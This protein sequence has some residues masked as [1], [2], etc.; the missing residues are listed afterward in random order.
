MC[1]ECFSLNLI[2]TE[3]NEVQNKTGIYLV[4]WKPRMFV[5]DGETIVITRNGKVE[6]F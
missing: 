2:H 4:R 6:H 3:C 1:V 5:T